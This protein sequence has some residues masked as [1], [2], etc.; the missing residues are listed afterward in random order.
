MWQRLKTFSSTQT[1][2]PITTH[3][4]KSRRDN[5][6]KPR[7]AAPASPE[8]TY[9]RPSIATLY[10]V[11]LSWFY[12]VGMLY[13]GLYGIMRMNYSTQPWNNTIFIFKRAMKLITWFRI[14]FYLQWIYKIQKHQLKIYSFEFLPSLDV[15]KKNMKWGK[16]FPVYSSSSHKILI[17]F[18]FLNSNYLFCIRGK[19]ILWYMNL[20]SYRITYYCNT[21]HK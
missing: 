15:T 2:H 1:L 3:A 13:S 16:I 19:D 21:N 5:S 6:N 8:I 18:L 9:T 14:A 7:V 20:D 4:T 10:I 11:Y 12:F 17:A